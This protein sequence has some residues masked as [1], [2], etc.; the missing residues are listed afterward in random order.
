[1]RRS[2]SCTSLFRL[3]LLALIGT[4][5]VGQTTTVFRV[6][7]TVV[8]SN[9]GSPVPGCHLVAVRVQHG[10]AGSSFTAPLDAAD[11]DEHGHFSLTVPSAGSWSLQASARGYRS[12][13]YDQHEGF[14]SAIILTAAAPSI[15]LLF[16]LTP[17]AAITGFVLDEA[18]EP[19]R[20]AQ[21]SLHVVLPEASDGSQPSRI[22]ANASTDDR[23]HYELAGLGPGD[24]RLSVRA[25]PWYAAAAQPRRFQPG[26]TAPLDPSLDV[27]YP[28]TW[29]PGGADSETAT[30]ITLHGGETR[31]ADF[32]LQPIQSIHLHIP[33]QAQN[34]APNEGSRRPVRLPQIEPASMGGNSSSISTT[35][36]QQGQIDVGGLAPGL[37]RVQF[38]EE[39]GQPGH[40][41]LVQVTPGSTRTLDLATASST[42]IVSLKIEGAD[43]NSVTVTFVDADNPQ[44]VF[45]SNSGRGGGGLQRRQTANSQANPLMPATLEIPPGRY[46]VYQS[47]PG[48]F[49]A[50]IAVAGKDQPGRMATI[51]VGESSVTVRLGTG[52][53]AVT[54]I[55]SFEGKPSVG[56]LVLLVP[57]TVDEPGSITEVH[58]DQTNTDGSFDLPG[59]I[60]GQ[61]I[62][63]ALD[64]GWRI[65]W[66]DPATLRRYL[67]HG[68]PLDLRPS[69]DA[70]Q[71]LDAQAP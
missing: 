57:I 20:R 50:G 21:V 28:L 68:T 33:V 17:D 35:V 7:G 65:H 44:N 58:R 70:K 39:S 56:A 67:I 64:H 23:G 11:T 45:R 15:D 34:P 41:S 53:A 43:P 49:L 32:Q 24:Y 1:M 13:A 40:A 9:D 26:A 46:L 61:Y 51:P 37:Y 5:A 55:A 54:G 63:I 38:P 29:F 25:Q 10:V 18:N 12:Q 71:D 30:T 8:S 6:T 69:T 14:S 66:S 3:I 47:N 19:V 60:P 4:S 42:A 59:V 27:V 31:Q 2:L 48:N 52:R 16:H 62:L 36:D 22:R